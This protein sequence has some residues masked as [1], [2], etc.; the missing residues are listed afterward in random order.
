MF[1]PV[2]EWIEDTRLRFEAEEENEDNT[3]LC[4]EEHGEIF[5]DGCRY[6]IHNLWRRRNEKQ[7][8]R[9][10]VEWIAENKNLALYW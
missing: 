1:P 7:T 8:E 4:G 9:L 10:R 2:K 3:K 5:T 6:D